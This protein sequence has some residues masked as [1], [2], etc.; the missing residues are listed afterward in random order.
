MLKVGKTMC[1][2]F[3]NLISNKEIQRYEEKTRTLRCEIIVVV[4]VWVVFSMVVTVWS[5]R[6]LCKI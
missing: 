2:S 5:C 3:I 1:F 4:K 6:F